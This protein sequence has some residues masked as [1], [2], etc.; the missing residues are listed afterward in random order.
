MS[1]NDIRKAVTNE[2]YDMQ[3]GPSD[4]TATFIIG[5][6]DHTLGNPLRHIIM[7]QP[8]TDFCGYSVP[9]PYEPKMNIRVQSH[10]IPAVQV[11][12]KSLTVMESMC[13]S[14]DNEFDRALDEFMAKR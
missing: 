10:S 4:K 5:N 7:Q 1:V 13:D 6:E 8:E 11:F 9:H 14:L 3:P 12:Q 2:L